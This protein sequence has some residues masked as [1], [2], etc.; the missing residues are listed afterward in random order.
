MRLGLAD[1]LEAWPGHS[2]E[3]TVYLW[4]QKVL[5]Y[6][7]SAR[8]VVRKVFTLWC[9]FVHAAPC[10]AMRLVVGWITD[11]KS[12]EVNFGYREHGVRKN[13][14]VKVRVCP[15]CAV[16]MFHKKVKEMKRQQRED[17]HKRSERKKKKKSRETS[18]TTKRHRRD[19]S[20]TRHRKKHRG[21]PHRPATPDSTG[22][23]QTEGQGI[24]STAVDTGSRDRH[25]SGH[26]L[27]HLARHPSS[28]TAVSGERAMEGAHENPS[29]QSGAGS[30]A[31]SCETSDP[32]KA[33][34][35]GGRV[36]DQGAGTR[37]GSGAGAGSGASAD[38]GDSRERSRVLHKHHHRSPSPAPRDHP[39]SDRAPA[40]AE[41]PSRQDA[42]DAFFDELL[43]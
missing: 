4:Q 13:A 35:T 33:P 1:V 25:P 40:E 34:G 3:G 23:S 6:H 29:A 16:K 31:R 20:S 21:P 15:R 30:R 41:P 36:A 37:S 14:L 32:G 7:R 17:R 18:R 8:L 38:F 24:T 28:S 12:Y 26:D 2:W 39:P 22:A 27:V 5:F 43:M 11:L 9:L 10:V 42:F 19:S